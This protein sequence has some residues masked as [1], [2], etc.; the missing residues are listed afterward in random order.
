MTDDLVGAQFY[1]CNFISIASVFPV[2][3]FLAIYF[4]YF[5][6]VSFKFIVFDTQNLRLLGCLYRLEYTIS[7]FTK[8]FIQVLNQIQ[9]TV[10]IPMIPV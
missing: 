10:E 7:L 6:I 9:K 4:C 3:L 8:F 1:F 2:F 5:L